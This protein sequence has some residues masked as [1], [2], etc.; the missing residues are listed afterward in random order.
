MEISRFE[1][2]IAEI[3]HNLFL[4]I[5]L[6]EHPEQITSIALPMLGTGNQQ[7][8]REQIFLPL[9][10]ECLNAF[11]L[12]PNLKKIILFEKNDEKYDYMNEELKK[13]FGRVRTGMVFIS[14]SR[15]DVEIARRLAEK[16]NAHGL[17]VWIDYEQIHHPNYGAVI[18]EGIEASAAYVILVSEASQSSVDV[19]RELF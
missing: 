4:S 6:L 10:E 13:N 9:L 2:R 17:K 5:R 1:G 16:L 8:N 3:F 18:V 11:E 19:Q 7:L 15:K 12:L 14:Y